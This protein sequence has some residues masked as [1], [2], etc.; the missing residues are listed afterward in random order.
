MTNRAYW[1]SGKIPRLIR[2]HNPR[3]LR[4]ILDKQPRP[5]P[6]RRMNRER[7]KANIRAKAAPIHES[8]KHESFVLFVPFC[9]SLP[10]ASVFDH[11]VDV[12][13]Q[14]DMSQHVAADGD[15]VGVLAFGHGAD[16][17]GDFHGD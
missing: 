16:L 11:D 14:I 5:L 6:V 3:R 9:G 15:D 1:Q 17:I 2:Q 13:Q 10:S 7:A 4:H 8:F 12:L